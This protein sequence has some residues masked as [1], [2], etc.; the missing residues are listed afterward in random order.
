MS[1]FAAPTVTLTVPRSQP[2]LLSKLITLVAAAAGKEYKLIS[3]RGKTF[4][5]FSVWSV[6]SK[7]KAAAAGRSVKRDHEPFVAEFYS[8]QLVHSY[9]FQVRLQ[10]ARHVDPGCLCWEGILNAVRQTG[11]IDAISV[12]SQ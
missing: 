7:G 3:L 10:S 9:L 11:G 2:L 5:P 6:H 1:W 4:F 12:P 8:E